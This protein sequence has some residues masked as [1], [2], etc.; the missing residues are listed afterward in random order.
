VRPKRCGV[1]H[2]SI[3]KLPAGISQAKAMLVQDLKRRWIGTC[4]MRVTS[5]TLPSTSPQYSIIAGCDG[6][7]DGAY[8]RHR[9]G[10]ESIAEALTWRATKWVIDV[11]NYRRRLVVQG[12]I[13][14]NRWKKVLVR[15]RT[16]SSKAAA[17]CQT[18]R[19]APSTG[20]GFG[21]DTTGMPNMLDPIVHRHAWPRPEWRSL[22]PAF[23]P[24]SS[25]ALL[26]NTA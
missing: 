19:M 18:A 10:E 11:R 7:G 2:A 24:A 5:C 3:Y 1:C 8:L 13:R 15:P 6:R 4:S 17:Q 22:R 20:N 23:Q 16:G 14:T 25:P 21:Q 26:A 9:A 12:P